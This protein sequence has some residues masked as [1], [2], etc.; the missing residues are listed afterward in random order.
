MQTA[1][2][3]TTLLIATLAVFLVLASVAVHAITQ[4]NPADDQ[5]TN[6]VVLLITTAAAAAAFLSQRDFTG[7]AARLIT[8]MRAVGGVSMALPIVAAGF[9]TY[10]EVS[11][12]SSG[13]DSSSPGPA[14]ASTRWASVSLSVLAL[15][16]F[17]L[18]LVT[19][20]RTRSDE[21]RQRQTSPWDMSLQAHPA[22][23][24]PDGLTYRKALEEFGFQRHA[25]GVRSS[26]GWHHV[27]CWTDQ[28]HAD[29]RN[30][31]DALAASTVGRLPEACTKALHCAG[32]GVGGCRVH[33]VASHG[34]EHR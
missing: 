34:A 20:L 15:A 25:V 29:A 10:H 4:E 28:D 17:L 16:L 30:R 26:E 2:W 33:I 31:L 3:L 9:L 13:S 8:G 19:W 24:R 12:D 32:A 27:Y 11:R 21:R 14:E 1:G 5:D 7:V 6:A 22:P 18:V 23:E